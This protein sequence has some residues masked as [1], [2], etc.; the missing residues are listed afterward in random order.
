[1]KEIKST[2]LSRAILSIL[3]KGRINRHTILPEKRI[4]G[5]NWKTKVIRM[6]M[7]CIVC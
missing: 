6:D 2:L 1:L 3:Q 7:A 4:R 5:G